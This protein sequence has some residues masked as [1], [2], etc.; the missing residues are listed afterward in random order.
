M[1]RKKQLWHA[2]VISLAIVSNPCPF[3]A[4]AW[5]YPKAGKAWCGK[6]LLGTLNHSLGCRL[7]SL[8]GSDARRGRRQQLNS[9]PP[10][11][12]HAAKPTNGGRAPF[13]R[14]LTSNGR[15]CYLAMLAFTARR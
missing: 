12:L 7:P 2:R 14:F 8:A 10:H 9:P 5:S 11:L 4:R 13:W 15:V 3:S 6:D 1:G